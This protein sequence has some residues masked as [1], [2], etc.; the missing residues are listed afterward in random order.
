[1]GVSA[2]CHPSI[3]KTFHLTNRLRLSNEAGETRVNPIR[4]CVRCLGVCAAVVTLVAC[5]TLSSPASAQSA[6]IVTRLSPN[7]VFYVEWH[8]NASLADAK[9][10][11][12]VLE[13][14]HDPAFAPMLNDL[15]S[16]MQKGSAKTL[17]PA[18]AFVL[19]DL[20]S[21]LDN[22]AVFGVAINPGAPM[23]E[24]GK[25]ST[26]YATFLVYDATGK[27][28]LIQRWKALSAL[29]S[30]TQMEVTKYDFGGT[31]VEVR[32]SANNSTYIAQ[33]GNYFVTSDQKPVME[34]L[35]TRFR[36]TERP[37]SSVADLPDY[38]RMQKYLGSNPALD[39][40]IRI[41]GMNEWNL[42]N[43][44]VR[45]AQQFFKNIHLEKVHAIGWSASFDGEATR[46]RG[47]A[48]GDTSAGGPFDIAGASGTNFDTLPVVQAAPIFSITRLDLSA[49]YQLINN[50]ITASM[51]AQQ[52]AQVAM[53]EAAAQ[54]F[55]GMPIPDALNLFTGEIA[56]ADL[57]ADDGTVEQVYAVG[58]Q[59]PESVLRVLRAVIGTMIVGEDS[60]G[61]TTFLDLAYPYTDPNTHMQRKKF[62]YAAVTP[63]MILTAPHKTLLRQALGRLTSSA[64]TADPPAA[65]VLANP[66][67]AQFRANLPEK[68]SGMS[69]ADMSNIPLDKILHRLMSQTGQTTDQQLLDLSRMN[70]DL[71]SHYMHISVGGWW[72]DSTG[73]YFDSYIQ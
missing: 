53:S 58:I 12:H 46:I 36:A 18:A 23:P 63:H 21:F 67:Y 51:P 22:A 61:T 24:P 15:A 66:A 16:Q 27:A 34:D 32:A 2:S 59:K 50:A 7:T 10:K 73:V 55:L 6:S 5:L 31:S 60:S 29:G 11:N 25:P 71:L 43:Q 64:E 69:G 48:M 9:Q 26:R 57:F 17:G 54:G 1:V 28:D 44:T 19:P 41:P 42:S 72:K 20:S 33:A 49:T 52:A 13:L 47:A 37:S 68:L 56:S 4:V 45:T 65:G 38:G 14:L 40:F 70:L 8:G 3:E 62:Y 35:I 39:F 30:K